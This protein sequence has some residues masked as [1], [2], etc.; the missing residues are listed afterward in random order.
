MNRKDRLR[1]FVYS[2]GQNECEWGKDDC[3]AWAAKWVES[4]RQIS[5]AL[6]EYNEQSGRAMI[7]ANGGLISLWSVHLVRAG[8]LETA[9]PVLGDIAIIKS[10][11]FGH[12]GV[13]VCSGGL[14][15]WRAQR[16]ATFIRPKEIVKA[17]SV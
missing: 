1:D 6:P 17:W 15:V 7:A 2:L 4:E 13:I 11:L 8:L 12:V 3:T 14:C 9:D 5:L 16:G 10:R